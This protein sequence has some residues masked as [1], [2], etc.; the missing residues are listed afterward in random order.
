MPTHRNLLQPINNVGSLPRNILVD[1]ELRV[2]F[3][4]GEQIEQLLIVE[5]QIGHADRILRV[6]EAQLIE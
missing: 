2:V 4:S 6:G 3:G 1:P 5:L